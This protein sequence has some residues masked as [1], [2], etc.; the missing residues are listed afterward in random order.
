MLNNLM[1]QQMRVLTSK[2]TQEWYTP[3]DPWINMVKQVFGGTINL[4]PASNKFAQEWIDSVLWYG[5]EQEEDGYPEFVDGLIPTWNYSN[6]AFNTVFCNPPYNGKAAHWVK[7]AE[8][9]YIES[10]K[11]Y[12]GTKMEIIMLVNN[13]AGYKWFEDMMDKW[14][15]CL[16]RDRIKFVDETG[17]QGGQ[18]KKASVF[19]YLGS[20]SDKFVEVFGNAGRIFFPKIGVY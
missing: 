1:S 3:N 9:E 11:E 20:N 7:K 18:A 4:D 14:T 8:Q 17:K 19:A 5:P 2:K 15:T 12:V 10:L 6:N 16:V 13:C